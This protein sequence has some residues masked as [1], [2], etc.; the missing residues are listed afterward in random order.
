MGLE[1][2]LQN[3]DPASDSQTPCRTIVPP[4]PL[5]VTGYCGSC[6]AG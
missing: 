6:E 2:S 3:V 5:A 4:E 1:V